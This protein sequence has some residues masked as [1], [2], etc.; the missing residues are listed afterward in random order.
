MNAWLSLLAAVLGSGVPGGVVAMPV[1]EYAVEVHFDG[2]PALL[3]RNHALVALPLDT[4]PGQ[5]T[6]DIT[7]HAGSLK[8][9]FNVAPKEFPV[10]RLT[11]AN[12]RMVNPNAEDLARISEETTR[13]RAGYALVGLGRGDLHPFLLPVE[14]EPSSPFGRRRILNGQP[15]SPHQGLDIAADTGTPIIAPAAGV[16]VVTGNFFFNGNTVLIDHGDGLVTMYCH[17][18]EVLVKEG[19]LLA[20]GEPFGSVGATGRATGP[21]LHWTVSMH[22][23]KV[24]PLALIQTLGEIERIE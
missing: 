3:H 10:Q 20:R 8:V 11:I 21:H 16:V 24:D 17:L 23:A 22:G 18:H 1:P 4:V 5:H 2:R 12:E 15:R 19:D 6:V 13:M 14:G 7:T 9:S